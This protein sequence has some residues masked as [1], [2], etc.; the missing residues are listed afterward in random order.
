M[1]VEYDEELILEKDAAPLAGDL[2]E[3]TANQAFGR[4]EGWE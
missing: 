2:H 1:R 4:D 3:R